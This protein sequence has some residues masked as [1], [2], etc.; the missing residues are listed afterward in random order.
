MPKRL[1]EA[2]GDGATG[3]DEAPSWAVRRQVLGMASGEVMPSKLGDEA[4]TRAHG[5]LEAG[6]MAG[7]PGPSLYLCAPF[8]TSC[9]LIPT[10]T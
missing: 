9:Y 3:D 1:K 6:T 4:E 7:P 10:L 2:V 8:T 5:W